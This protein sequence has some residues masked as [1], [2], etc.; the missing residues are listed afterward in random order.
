V[1]DKA[2]HS[3]S[4]S[5]R[6]VSAVC[7]L[8]PV[9]TE[10]GIVL[11]DLSESSSPAE[12][13][14]VGE[15]DEAQ[16][17]QESRPMKTRLLPAALTPRLARLNNAVTWRSHTGAPGMRGPK[18]RREIRTPPTIPPLRTAKRGRAN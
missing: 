16:V 8:S 7:R 4:D 5:T 1:C 15:G 14:E 13:V 3:N 2:R 11:G 9:G 17:H 18:L 10:E 6:S 12:V